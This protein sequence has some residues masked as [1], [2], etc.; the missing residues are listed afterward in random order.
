LMTGGRIARV[1]EVNQR[2]IEIARSDRIERFGRR[3]CSLGLPAFVSE[4]HP[5]RRQYVR[6]IVG[7]QGSRRRYHWQSGFHI[8]S[9]IGS[10]SPKGISYF[11]N[12]SY[13][14]GVPS[15]KES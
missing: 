11:F 1:I 12:C 9:S 5:Q 2:E 14:N 15:S 3:T 6:M 4:Q 8:A 10:P 7:D 13:P